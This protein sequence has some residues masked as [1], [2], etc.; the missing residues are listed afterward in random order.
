[1]LDIQRL[2]T[3]F[4]TV[5]SWAIFTN[6][7]NPVVSKD[8]IRSNCSAGKEYGLECYH[9]WNN[10]SPDLSLSSVVQL[11]KLRNA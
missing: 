10:Q 9:T 3:E 8:G 1:M 7:V 5:P 2:V 4:V 6:P 11:H